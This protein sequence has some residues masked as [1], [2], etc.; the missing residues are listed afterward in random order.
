MSCATMEVSRPGPVIFRCEGCGALS[1]HHPYVKPGSP[2]EGLVCSRC[3]LVLP[4]VRFCGTPKNK[5]VYFGIEQ[6]NYMNYV[7]NP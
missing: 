3:G 6:A 7:A 4:P 2:D 5:P 1:V